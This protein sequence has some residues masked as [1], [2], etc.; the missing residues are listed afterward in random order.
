MRELSILIGVI[1]A[2]ITIS[3]GLLGCDDEQHFCDKMC[4]PYLEAEKE[5]ADDY[6]DGFDESDNSVKQKCIDACKGEWGGLSSG[7]QDDIEVCVDCVLDEVGNS[8]DYEDIAEAVDDCDD[9]CDD[10]DIG[11][12]MGDFQQEW[13]CEIEYDD[14]EC[15]DEMEEAFDC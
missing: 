2:G 5:W 15:E 10:E 8:P 3:L 11:D 14:S 12:F 7:D 13:Y 9:E 1:T 4:S 6:C